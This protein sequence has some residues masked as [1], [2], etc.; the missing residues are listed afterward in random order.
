MHY[1]KE[2]AEVCIRGISL[3]TDRNI[4]ILGFVMEKAGFCFLDRDWKKDEENIN[5]FWNQHFSYEDDCRMLIMFPEGT[6]R[7]ES[8][9]LTQIYHSLP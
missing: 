4:P 8:S 1:S 6:T 9:F 2:I 3:L 7:D 5:S